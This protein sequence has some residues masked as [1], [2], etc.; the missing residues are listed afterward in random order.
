LLDWVQPRD[1]RQH[2]KFPAYYRW[3][4]GPCPRAVRRLQRTGYEVLEYRGLFGHPYYGQRG[5][6]A[7]ASGA[8]ARFLLRHPRPWLTSYAYLALQTL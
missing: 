8:A 3:C 7:R 1:R 5:S 6:L 2:G 4:R